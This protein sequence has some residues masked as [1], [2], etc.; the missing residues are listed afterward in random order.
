MGFGQMKTTLVE[1][2]EDKQKIYKTLLLEPKNLSVLGNGIPLKIIDAL[3]KKPA[4]A[5][6]IARKL[7]IHEQK[8]YYHMR[9][10]EKSG[11][12]RMI[13]TESRYGM[14]AKMYEVVSPVVATKLY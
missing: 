6:D 10:L 11:I 1:N 2:L 12:I 14:T 13:S 4:C 3:S 9:N 5:M 8:I 7:K